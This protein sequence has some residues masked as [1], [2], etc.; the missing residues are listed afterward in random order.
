MLL[1]EIQ[2][3]ASTDPRAF[4]AA[5]ETNF[6][7]RIH[8]LADAVA[9]DAER[10]PFVLISG[11]SGSGKTT[12]A[13]RIAE[14]LKQTGLEAHIISL[15][16][17]FRTFTPEETELFLRHELDLE[18]P[19]RM[20]GELLSSQL[21]LLVKGQEVELPRYDFTTNA[22]QPSGKIIKLHRGEV[23]IF[24]GIHALNPSVLGSSDDYS[25]RI[26]VSVR[27]R[28]DHPSAEGRALLHPSK[29]RV[30][31]RMIRDRRERA[32]SLSAVAEL[33]GSVERGENLYIMPYKHRADFDVDTFVPYELCVY[34]S[35]LPTGL[36][37]DEA[38]HAW[39]TEMFDVLNALPAIPPELVPEDSLMREFI[40][41]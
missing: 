27:T 10:C 8:T 23:L 22:S 3:R 1:E 2:R 36:P 15:D 7:E 34:K 38:K 12:T 9:R 5:C 37:E 13:H 24:E 40:G 21:E 20:N 4:V 6:K 33:Y 18:S 11:P 17:Y 25:T 16:N 19:D 14:R 32:R 30:A 29:V 28:I 35:F 26:Y 41:Q 31:R 39:L